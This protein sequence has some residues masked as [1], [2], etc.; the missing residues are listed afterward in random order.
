ML[1][2]PLVYACDF[3]QLT[4]YIKVGSSSFP[5]AKEATYTLWQADKTMPNSITVW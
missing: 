1:W 2:L 4:L 5:G 3:S